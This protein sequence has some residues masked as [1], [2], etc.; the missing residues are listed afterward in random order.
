M[1][2]L[3]HIFRRKELYG[4]LAEEMRLHLEERTEQ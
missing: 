2:W 3:S 1:N 4:D